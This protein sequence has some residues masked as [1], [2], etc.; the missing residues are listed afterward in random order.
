MINVFTF[1][2]PVDI[3]ANQALILK[4]DR[5]IARIHHVPAWYWESHD[6]IVGQIDVFLRKN[7]MVYTYFL[8]YEDQQGNMFATVYAFANHPRSWKELGRT[9][10]LEEARAMQVAV[11]RHWWEGPEHLREQ[12][13][14]PEPLEME[15]PPVP[16]AH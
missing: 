10:T 14:D 8:C 7:V 16:L 13:N 3:P 15:L 6:R 2:K 11:R 9:K 1:L 5:T 4:P 12:P